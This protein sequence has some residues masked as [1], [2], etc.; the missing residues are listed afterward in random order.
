MI[1]GWHAGFLRGNVQRI[2]RSVRQVGR[3]LQVRWQLINQGEINNDIADGSEAI[4][5]KV[6]PSAFRVCNVGRLTDR[7]YGYR[8]FWV[9]RKVYFES[10]P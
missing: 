3:W 1:G 4:Q 7:G 9:Y 5:C 8:R 10:S 6:P 2:S